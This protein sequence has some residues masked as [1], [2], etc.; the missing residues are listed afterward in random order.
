[1]RMAQ[2][3]LMNTACSHLLNKFYDLKKS[4]SKRPFSFA[5]RVTISFIMITLP[6]KQRIAPVFIAGLKKV[7]PSI[8]V[9]AI[10]YRV[11]N[12]TRSYR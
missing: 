1:M 7:I 8:N 11:R 10:Q 4:Q 3:G 5:G 6:V 9:P 2:A 12:G